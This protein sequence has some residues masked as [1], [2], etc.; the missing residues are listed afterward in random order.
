[1]IMDHYFINEHTIA[2]LPAKQIEYQTTVIETNNILRINKTPLQI[3]K[4]ACISNW[5]SYEG[6]RRAVIHHTK[7]KHKV[8]IPIHIEKQICAFPTHSP[9]HFD[10][11]WIFSNHI[12]Q[13][14]KCTTSC[15]SVVEFTNNRQL[16]VN[17]SPYIL[18]KQFQRSLS[19]MTYMSNSLKTSYETTLNKTPESVR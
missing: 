12:L 10:C 15:R 11:K 18:E 17:V 7:Y 2:L 14:K 4:D 9:T 3:I 16:K 6:R 8:P 19:C 1:M 5:S 13:L